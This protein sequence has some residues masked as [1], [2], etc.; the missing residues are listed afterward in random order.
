MD[1]TH[2]LTLARE[3]M[4]AYGLQALPVGWTRAKRQF[5]R[6][7]FTRDATG[8]RVAKAI[9]I[10]WPLTRVNPIEV[11]RNTILHEIAHAL[12][13]YDA[14]HGPAWVAMAHRVGAR[15][16]RCVPDGDP[17]VVDI[18]GRF[19]YSCPVC[20]WT[21]N[22]HK[23]LRRNSSCHKCS[24]GTYNPAFELRLAVR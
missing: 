22:R 5:G 6:C 2:A 12:A 20:P 3:L 4:N 1:T 15:P 21:M 13:G 14:A 23:R 18:L 16:E 9:E 8:R 19:T 11:V 7:T 10:S 17:T 24:H